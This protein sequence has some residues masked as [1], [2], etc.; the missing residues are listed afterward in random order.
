M[1]SLFDL[2]MQLFAVYIQ[3]RPNPLVVYFHICLFASLLMLFLIIY[4]GNNIFINKFFLLIPLPFVVLL[5]VARLLVAVAD[6]PDLMFVGGVMRWFG[7]VAI[8]W[9]ESFDAFVGWFESLFVPGGHEL[10][11]RLRATSSFMTYRGKDLCF[12]FLLLFV[13]LYV[14]FL[15]AP[16]CWFRN[17]INSESRS[18]TEKRIQKPVLEPQPEPSSPLA[19][20][21]RMKRR[22][23]P[24][25]ADQQQ[26]QGE[27]VE[28][29]EAEDAPVAAE[30]AT[31]SSPAVDGK[32][33]SATSSPHGASIGVARVRQQPARERDVEQWSRGR[34]RVLA[35][36]L[37]IFLSTLIMIAYTFCGLELLKRALQ[38]SLNVE[39]LYVGSM[40]MADQAEAW[41]SVHVKQTKWR[42][43]FEALP[44]YDSASDD[45]DN[46][47]F[48][49]KLAYARH[50]ML[51][52]K[53][54]L[55]DLSASLSLAR[56]LGPKT[57]RDLLKQAATDSQHRTSTDASLASFRC[58]SPRHPLSTAPCRNSPVPCQES[59]VRC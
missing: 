17:A 15:Q 2:L 11:I 45:K 7:D 44:S 33:H 5:L 59:L 28:K 43:L 47:Y 26:P 24:P 46:R 20:L 16:S 42:A 38:M 52:N 3:A 55:M 58:H 9:F 18:Y 37:P 31:A 49:E 34:R 48:A 21:Q 25:G 40:A 54:R 51:N 57:E 50:D 13:L 14:V 1:A 36:K 23:V 29:R 53:V 10:S 35:P 12:L 32:G 4:I 8:G 41:A 27:S 22:K 19:F 30:A 39:R 6:A 56:I